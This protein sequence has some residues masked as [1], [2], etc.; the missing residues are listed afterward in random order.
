VFVPQVIA[1]RPI[2]AGAIGTDEIC[3]IVALVDLLS[4]EFPFSQGHENEAAATEDLDFSP[5]IMTPHSRH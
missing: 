4:L 1:R 3:G 2:V 5:L